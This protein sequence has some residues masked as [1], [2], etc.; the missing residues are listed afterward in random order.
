MTH[1]APNVHWPVAA[2]PGCWR[3]AHVKRTSAWNEARN[4]SHKQV[5]AG[6]AD[7]FT[8]GVWRGPPDAHLFRLSGPEPVQTQVTS[9]MR[10][11][12]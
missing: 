10:P 9:V 6:F 5:R 11:K 1:G 12:S 8:R 3:L 4:D 2:C 7:V